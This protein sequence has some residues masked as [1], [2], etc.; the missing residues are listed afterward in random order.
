MYFKDF[1]SKQ[2]HLSV[3]ESGIEWGFGDFIFID[4]IWICV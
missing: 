1:E 3:C 4:Y 2:K